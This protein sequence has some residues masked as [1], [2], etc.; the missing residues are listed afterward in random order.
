MKLTDGR[1]VTASVPE[2][3][4]VGSYEANYLSPM[5]AQKNVEKIISP[6][7]KGLN[8]REQKEIDE[9]LIKLDGT[10]AKKHLGA[11]AILGVSIAC[12]RAG[13]LESK[14]PLW[15]H[16]RRL[17]RFKKSN[18]KS[19]YPHLFI[20]IINGGQHAENNLDFQE[21]LVV[22]KTKSLK[23]AVYIGLK[24]YSGVKT[25]LSKPKGRSG[26]GVGDEGGFDPNFKD[27]LEPFRILDKVAKKLLIKSKIN[28][29]LDVAANNVAMSPAK[30][31]SIY[32]K[33]QNKFNLFYFED[34]YKEDD[35]GKFA[36]LRKVL[37]E[38]ILIAGDDLTTTNL[39][40]IKKAYK[41]KSINA[42]IIKPNQIGTVSESI[43][44]VKLARKFGWK[45][46]VSHRS[47]ET[48]DDFI[49]DFAYGV[50]ADGFKLGAPAREERIVKYN[51]LLEIESLN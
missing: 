25:Y 36:Q 30:L 41:E 45:V 9:L 13:A 2:G 43:E 20:N 18:T 46:I 33:L 19:D 44:A 49:A 28:F 50:M 51:R 29:G 16:L 40:R 11:N 34:P 7:L 6:R 22:P 5:I 38:R 37:G 12:A 27:N 4:S 17:G 31:T 14:R 48:N 23:E 21:Y 10:P 8:P 15:E 32:R 39:T 24:L 3:K 1:V 26:I 42:V 35:F 47:G